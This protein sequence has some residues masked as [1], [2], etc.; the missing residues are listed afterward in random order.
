MSCTQARNCA[1][2]LD[3]LLRLAC[4]GSSSPGYLCDCRH[5][6]FLSLR[7]S[8]QPQ[9]RTHT[10]KN[11][12]LAACTNGAIFAESGGAQNKVSGLHA[13]AGLSPSFRWP[14]AS[15]S[16]MCS[17]SLAMAFV[18]AAL[19]LSNR[20]PYTMQVIPRAVD[21]SETA[22]TCFTSFYFCVSQRTPS[23]PLAFSWPTVQ[24]WLS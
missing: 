6:C 20:R 8:C 13:I 19:S 4:L 2:R 15:R 11:K 23:G 7:K 16:T 14:G 12:R 24:A 3:L 22:P 9:A 18:F 5:C 17:N 10:K 1:F 21:P